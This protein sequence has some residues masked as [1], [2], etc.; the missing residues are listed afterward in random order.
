M[1]EEEKTKKKNLN[2]YFY[3]RILKSGPKDTFSQFSSMQFF[4][5]LSIN[6]NFLPIF[7]QCGEGEENSHIKIICY[8]MGH[9]KIILKHFILKSLGY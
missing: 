5:Y 3:L 9:Q 8:A 2:N 7:A 4:P 6:E 1:P